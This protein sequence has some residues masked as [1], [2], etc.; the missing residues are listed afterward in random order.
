MP[1]PELLAITKRATIDLVAQK[2]RP[3]QELLDRLYLIGLVH[4]G[5]EPEG[6]EVQ[7]AL[8]S[9][10]RSRRKSFAVPEPTPGEPRLPG[11]AER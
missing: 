3:S 2:G 8:A 9:G 10:R 4:A 6:D 7:R 5:E 11:E 1:D